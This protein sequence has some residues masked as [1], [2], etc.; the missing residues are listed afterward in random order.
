M[1][2]WHFYIKNL[3]LNFNVVFLLAAV[4][5]VLLLLF[6]AP[7]QGEQDKTAQK[8]KA[9]KGRKAKKRSGDDVDV[10]TGTETDIETASTG[11]TF[12]Y[13]L[14][15]FLTFLI[16]TSLAHKEE[17]FLTMIYPT[18]CLA[19]A[20]SVGCLH[21]GLLEIIHRVFGSSAT[22]AT[23]A[24]GTAAAALSSALRLCIL[25]GLG[26][27]TMLSLSRSTALHVNFF[28]PQVSSR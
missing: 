27:S 4:M 22:G 24:T 6:G 20:I 12:I 7:A 26:L 1:E 15:T 23:G 16:F 21:R 17:R 8:A 3:A 28:A 13:L 11:M 2:P 10:D 18:L 5:P 14:P 25:A 9:P 19:S